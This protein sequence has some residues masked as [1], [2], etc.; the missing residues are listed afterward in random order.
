[1]KTMILFGSTYGYTQE[2]A[3]KL[4]KDLGGEVL[5]VNAKDKIP[6]LEDYDTIL[7]GGSIYMGQIQKKI[8]EYCISNEEVLKN[9]NL[10]FF[11]SSGIPENFDTNI[12]NAFPESLLKS[13]LSIENFGGELRTEKMKLSHKLL[14]AMM[15]KATAKE[16]KPPTEPL[17]E[18]IAKMAKT[19]LQMVVPTCNTVTP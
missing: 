19:I 4:T 18:N 2:C 8:K 14:T 16:N 7:I 12:K 3:T 9:K 5:L 1:M 6:S 13:A 17:P 10:G 15:K 11:V